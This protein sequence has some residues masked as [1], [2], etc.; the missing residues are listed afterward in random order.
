MNNKFYNIVAWTQLAISLIL[1]SAIIWG[2]LSYHSSVGQFVSTIAASI[3]A[4]S[5]GVLR[6]A[7]SV[8]ASKDL[9]DE[10]G[11]MLASTKTLIVAFKTTAENHA[12][13][14]PNYASNLQTASKISSSLGNT[15]EA[16][17]GKLTG[18]S[19]PS[20]IQMQGVKPVI[21]MSSPFVKNGQELTS[22]AGELKAVGE[23]LALWSQT[24]ASDQQSLSSAIVAE[25]TQALK[26]IDAAEKTLLQLKSQGLPKAIND[27]KLAS[28]NLSKV[29]AQVEMASNSAIAL[30]VIGLLLSLW[31]FIHSLGALLLSKSFTQSTNA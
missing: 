1:A 7:E 16:L 21:I 12:K 14:A 10:T 20:G 6:T 23:T 4:V 25:S 8:E 22:K 28:A 5:T 27:L 11:Q 15:I 13:N 19:V 24:M 17:G 26:V 29:S 3:G 9:L 30:L 31:C 18:L 2:Y